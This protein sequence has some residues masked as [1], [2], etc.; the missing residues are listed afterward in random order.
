MTRE[1]LAA[2]GG[3]DRPAALSEANAAKIAYS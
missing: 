2:P 1:A 3:S